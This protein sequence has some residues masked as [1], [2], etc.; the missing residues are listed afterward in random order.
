MEGH[1][2]L[3]NKRKYIRS[4]LRSSGFWAVFG[5]ILVL[6]AILA[7]TV[8]LWAQNQRSVDNTTI[9]RYDPVEEQWIKT[10]LEI[11]LPENPDGSRPPGHRTIEIHLDEDN[12]VKT[13]LIEETLI[14]DESGGTGPLLEIKGHEPSG[15]GD[16]KINIGTLAFIEVDAEELEIDADVVRVTLENVVAEDDELD[17]DLNIVNVVRTG[18]GAASTLLLGISRFS[19]LEKFGT[20]S[21]DLELERRRRGVTG[22]ETGL[23]VDR[24]RIIGPDSGTGFVET[25]VILQS[26]VFGKIEVDDVRIQDLILEQVSLDD[27]F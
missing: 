11:V 26:S 14:I 25:L 20:A 6:A 27:S 15:G 22:R 23:R 9:Y 16:G 17:L 2:K 13:I 24:I 5:L 10:V 1:K 21:D 3:I 18:R 4:V 7:G 12:P 19:L 8:V